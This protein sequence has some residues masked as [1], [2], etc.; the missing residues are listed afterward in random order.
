MS[1]ARFLALALAVFS[2]SAVEPDA[3]GM[4]RTISPD[5]RFEVREAA[6]ERNVVTV[7][8]LHRRRGGVRLVDLASAYE[9]T[10]RAENTQ[11]SWRRDSRAFAFH[12]AFLKQGSTVVYRLDAQGV[13]QPL[14]FPKLP[15]MRTD[16]GKVV[17][18]VELNIQADTVY[19]IRWQ[20]SDTLILEEFRIYGGGG[21]FETTHR[22]I[23]LQVPAKGPLILKKVEQIEVSQREE[24]NQ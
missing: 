7:A 22:K 15:P 13:F 6:D 12:Y 24:G 9:L 5:Q 21:P 14:T 18:E 20:G 19:P 16:D 17:P 10:G 11:T 23:V 1:A 8:A 4:T 3:T 2:A